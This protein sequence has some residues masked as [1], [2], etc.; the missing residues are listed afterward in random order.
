MRVVQV[1]C[2]RIGL[3]GVWERGRLVAGRYTDPARRTSHFRKPYT[4]L[5]QPSY[6]ARGVSSKTVGS[7]LC[8]L[9]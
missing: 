2:W 9:C 5:G 7:R 8:T 3:C 6:R 4:S 1:E